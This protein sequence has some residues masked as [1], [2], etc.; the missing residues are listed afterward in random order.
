MPTKNISFRLPIEP[1][2]YAQWQ[3]IAQENGLDLTALIRQAV[4]AQIE[5]MGYE[6]SKYPYA[7]GKKKSK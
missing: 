2:E 5:R 6:P 4:R 1:N 3:Q 7:S